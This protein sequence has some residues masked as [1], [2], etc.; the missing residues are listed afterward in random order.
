MPAFHYKNGMFNCTRDETTLPG[1]GA[2]AKPVK[3]IRDYSLIL[4]T[5]KVARLFATVDIQ[6]WASGLHL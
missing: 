1:L 4:G 6:S 2:W 3:I 5:T